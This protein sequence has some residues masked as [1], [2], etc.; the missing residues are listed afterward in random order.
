MIPILYTCSLQFEDLVENKRML[1][2]SH[3]AIGN[4]RR[5]VPWSLVTDACYT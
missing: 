1:V 5:G 4:R 3:R 2:D